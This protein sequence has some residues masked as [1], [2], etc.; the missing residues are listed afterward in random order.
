MAFIDLKDGFWHVLITPEDRE[1]TA[2]MTP[3]GLYEWTV[4][5]FGLTNAPAT[6]QAL[7][8]EVLEPLRDFVSGLLDDVAVWGDLL[9]Q[10]YERLLLLFQRLETYGMLFN[11]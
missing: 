10:L 8:E 2:F 1:K 4:M 9:Q 11:T 6:F 3:N 7:M 5:P